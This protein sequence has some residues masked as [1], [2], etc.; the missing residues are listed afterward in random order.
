MMIMT[1][2]YEK[3]VKVFGLSTEE[4]KNKMI[5][6]GSFMLISYSLLNHEI[7]VIIV[8]VNCVLY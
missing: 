2:F 8:T 4:I 5:V 7:Y 3:M 6:L 1:T